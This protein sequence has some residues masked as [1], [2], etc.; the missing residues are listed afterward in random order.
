VDEV[1][2]GKLALTV[3]PPKLSWLLPSSSG[4]INFIP[5]FYTTSFS[6]APSFIQV[7]RERGRQRMWGMRVV[8][9]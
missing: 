6:E 3:T 2:V 8:Q 9:G 4:K 1:W 5:W 7:Q